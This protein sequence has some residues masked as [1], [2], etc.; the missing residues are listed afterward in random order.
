MNHYLVG[1]MVLLYLST[2]MKTLQIVDVDEI[3]MTFARKDQNC[4]ENSASSSNVS[5]K[6]NHSMFYVEKLLIRSE[7]KE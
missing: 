3:L 4:W 5:G 7:K 6:K 2:F 1:S